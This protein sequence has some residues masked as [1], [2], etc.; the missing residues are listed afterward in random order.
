LFSFALAISNRW[1]VPLLLSTPAL[2]TLVE[3]LRAN[4]GFLALPWGTLAHAQHQNLAIL[5]FA[6][7]AGEHGVTFLVA[8][9][10]SVIAQLVLNWMAK[11]LSYSSLWKTEAR[12]DFPNRTTA[13]KSP[14]IP[15]FHRGK[16]T[17]SRDL[18]LA[19]LIIAAVHAWGA[20]VL[21]TAHTGPK[22]RVAAVQP[23]I[24]IAERES[25]SGK[26]E[27]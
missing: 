14:S 16:Q 26:A 13:A 15:L 22:I 1:R 4:A 6:S 17:V 18:V 12:E 24:Q 10:N 11:S 19:I 25:K 20:L 8:L 3:Y 5:Q 9:G 2:W 27:S 23:N 21:F 7:I